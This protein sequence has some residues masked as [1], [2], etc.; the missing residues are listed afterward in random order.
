MRTSLLSAA[1]LIT[2]WLCVAVL[3]IFMSVLPVRAQ[4]P[5][6]VQ[7]DR[8]DIGIE[9]VP[10]FLDLPQVLVVPSG[11]VT[12]ISGAETYDY[13]EVQSGGELELAPGSALSTTHLFVLPGGRL[14]A[15]IPCGQSAE[16]VIR[17]TQIDTN[18]DPF[19]WGNGVL[20][21]GEMAATGCAKAS[22]AYVMADIPAGATSLTLDGPLTNWQAGDE[23]L[24]PDTLPPNPLPRRESVVTI[25][26]IAGQTVTLSKP[27]DFA[28]PAITTPDGEVVAWPRVEHVTRN[29]VV[30]TENPSG[31]RGHV[32]LVGAASQWSVAG[33]AFVDLGRTRNVPLDSTSPDQSH[34]G[35]NQVGRY[36]F[37]A[38][39]IGDAPGRLMTGSV[40]RGGLKWGL[41]VH[42]T[43]D[44]LV[45]SN[46]CFDVEGSCYVTEDGTEQRNTFRFNVGEYVL[47]IHDG[48]DEDA[49]R[50]LDEGCNGCDGAAFWF[51]GNGNY[52]EDNIA[53]TSTIGILAF[54]PNQGGGFTPIP[55]L[56][57]IRNQTLSN[58]IFGLEIWAID[59]PIEDHISAYNRQRQFFSAIS[60][61][62]RPYLR[63]PTMI[64]YQ[65][66]SECVKSAVAYNERLTIEGGEIRGCA[67]GIR[68]GGGQDLMTLDGVTFQNTLDIDWS[69]GKA[70]L[71]DFTDVLHE[72]MPGQPLQAE[73]WGDGSVWD[74]SDPMP[75]S[76]W[77]N[78]LPPDGARDVRRNW[79]GTGVDYEI[80]PPGN[81]G[82]APAKYSR[83]FND[84]FNC[85]A[86]GLTVEQ[87]WQ[88][89]GLAEH[90]DYVTDAEVVELDGIAGAIAR[91]ARP[92]TFIAPVC[93]ITFPTMRE[94]AVP[95]PNGSVIIRGVVTGDPAAAN[96]V[97]LV[98]ID[99]SD[100][101][102]FSQ[103][104]Y[105]RP[106]A[107][108]IGGP[109]TEGTHTVTTWRQTLGGATIVDSRQDFQYFVG[110]PSGPTDSDGD[111][112]PD[113]TDN[114]PSI[115]NPDQADN[116]GDGIGNVCDPTP[117]PPST[118][119]SF[120]GILEQLGDEDRV[121][122]CRQDDPDRC[123]EIVP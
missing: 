94:A 105:E 17:D 45:E 41:A 38:H 97:C 27:L 61:P 82:S 8:I 42:A 74:G 81:L 77:D 10:R 67:I 113:E 66:T 120:E 59:F 30:R 78:W 116:D 104:V 86:A 54:N 88:Q 12:T 65:G 43:N 98:S 93:T 69:Q 24:I 52:V 68:E 118:W 107:R 56:S 115:S 110:T 89:Y 114:C 15:N 60:I 40:I 34:I 55:P 91:I 63:N 73:Y 36:S 119:G 14:A 101:Y 121:R 39:M 48:T 21:F 70:R 123:W 44:V 33:A 87:C 53:G 20:I 122:I 23:L 11:Q 90:G 35:T 7:P 16:I 32:A 57:F 85:P 2:M 28:H 50:N 3:I 79:Q 102:P 100:P 96:D 64:G 75:V 58:A 37:H 29:V 80:F 4:I 26:A 13:V 95:D 49:F 109:G 71:T 19:Q 31:T 92:P 83:A 47:G 117:D 6:T 22:L 46:L 103:S 108:R 1:V 62:A 112:V 84:E 5:V 25:T 99:G 9:F 106:S 111:G 76:D 18:R 51:R 72:P